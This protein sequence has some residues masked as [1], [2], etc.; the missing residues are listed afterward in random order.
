LILQ[1]HFTLILNSI[2]QIDTKKYAKELSVMTKFSDVDFDFCIGTVSVITA[3]N[4]LLTGQIIR[5]EKRPEYKEFK[6][7][8]EEEK[9]FGKEEKT[10]V[11]IE[12]EVEVDVEE[13][14]I[15]MRLTEH[16]L[17]IPGAGGTPVVQPYYVIGDIIQINVSQIETVGPL[18]IIKTLAY[19]PALQ[20]FIHLMINHL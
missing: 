2:Y 4:L 12:N 11:K 18:H 8:K 9:E 20:G 1:K 14:F 13:E 10:H 6:D 3:N 17:V 7:C 19:I 16:F 5:D 15:T